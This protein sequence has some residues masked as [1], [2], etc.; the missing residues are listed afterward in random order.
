MKKDAGAET[1]RQN[2]RGT[3]SQK[4][5]R[6]IFVRFRSGAV[7]DL[8]LRH[9]FLEFGGVV[10]RGGGGP[11][12]PKGVVYQSRTVEQ[13]YQE[14]LGHLQAWANPMGL[15]NQSIVRAVPFANNRARAERLATPLDTRVVAMAV[16]DRVLGRGV[17]YILTVWVT[18]PTRARAEDLARQYGPVRDVFTSN[19]PD[20]TRHAT[21]IADGRVPGLAALDA[22]TVGIERFLVRPT[23]GS[24]HTIDATRAEFLRAAK[25]RPAW[26][27][28]D[29]WRANVAYDQER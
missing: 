24:P 8:W 11:G 12:L 26:V 23:P 5:V 21:A 10:A 1:I 15:A 9:G 7:V 22:A 18:A 14:A 3:G 28:A 2:Y 13:V 19:D 27:P 4:A 6:Q 17:G 25:R 20:G 29:A 16:V